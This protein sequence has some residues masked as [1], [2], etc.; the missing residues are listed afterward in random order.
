[1]YTTFLLFFPQIFK[2]YSRLVSSSSVAGL[3]LFAKGEVKNLLFFFL[4]SLLD[5]VHR[6]I[7][8]EVLGIARPTETKGSSNLEVF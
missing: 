1:M 8:I 5:F 3:C 7:V 4:I 2:V 6:L